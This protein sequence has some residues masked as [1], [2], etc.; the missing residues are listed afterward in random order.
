[1]QSQEELGKR[2]RML[3]DIA[4]AGEKVE[5]AL[6]RH[7]KDIDFA[8]VRLLEKRVEIAYKCVASPTTRAPAHPASHLRTS[9]CALALLLC[10]LF[11]LCCGLHGAV[12]LQDG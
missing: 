5:E 3:L 8:T 4:T 11:L 12:H 9:S 7:A 10:T 1:M 2:T 6:A